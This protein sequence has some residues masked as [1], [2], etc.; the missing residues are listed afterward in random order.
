MCSK[1]STVALSGE[2]IFTLPPMLLRWPPP[3]TTMPAAAPQAPGA[4]E[5]PRPKAPLQSASAGVEP[6]LWAAVVGIPDAAAAAGG[7]AKQG[8]ARRCSETQLANGL[9]LS[10]PGAVARPP[11]RTSEPALLER[12]AAAG[13]GA[14]AGA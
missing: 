11:G 5:L 2:N 6:D 12:S 4:G 7:A 10:P 13:T 14:A 8:A 3:T 1:A 9:P